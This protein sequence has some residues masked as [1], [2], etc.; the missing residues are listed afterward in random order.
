ML[1]DDLFADDVPVELPTTQ[2]DQEWF[3]PN[4]AIHLGARQV[5]RELNCDE[6]TSLRLTMFG[7]TPQ[8]ITNFLYPAPQHIAHPDATVAGMSDAARQLMEGIAR[9]ERIAI[10]ADYDVDGQ[11]SLADLWRPDR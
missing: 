4:P 2:P 9:G 6:I 1:L 10:Y 5:A 7:K 11:T 3:T 8:D